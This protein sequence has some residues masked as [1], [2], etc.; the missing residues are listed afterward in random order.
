MVCRHEIGLAR[1]QAAMAT[2]WIDAHQR[3]V[4]SHPGDRRSKFVD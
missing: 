1:A 3:Y 4:P 2:N